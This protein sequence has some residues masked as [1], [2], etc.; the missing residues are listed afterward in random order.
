VTAVWR[1]PISGKVRVQAA[2][3]DADAN[4][5]NGIDWALRHR[6]RTVA[7][8]H[9]ENAGNIEVPAHEIEVQAGD[10]VRL[11]IGP[12][13]EYS[14]DS[15]KVEFVIATG[16]QQWR[17]SE[18]FVQ[19][20]QLMSF[21]KTGFILAAGDAEKLGSENTALIEER[22]QLR[23]TL[24]ELPQCQGLQDGGI[25]LTAYEGFHDAKI[26][27]RGS[28]DRQGELVPRRFPVLLA[29]NQQA[30]IQKGS[31]RLELARWVASA[32]HPLTA[33][34]M[35]N[36]L[37]QHHF[38]EGI[39]RT[40]NNY[41]KLGTPPTHPELLDW[42]ALKFIE[43]GWSIKAMHRLM[44]LTQ[45]YQRA[46]DDAAPKTDAQNL[47][48]GRQNR[49]RLSAEEL[50][51]ALLAATGT[52]DATQG[53]LS[54]TNINSLRRTLYVTTIR[55]DRSSYQMLFDGADPNTIVEKRNDSIVAPQALWL[56]NHPF[57]LDRAKALSA[58]A[59]SKAGTD[60]TQ[61]IAWLY[62]CL[63]N[64]A[65]LPQE[66]ALLQQAL[67]AAPDRALA[68]EQVCHALLCSNEFAYVD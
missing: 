62:D 22:Q 46:A 18:S 51:D 42:L 58:R 53:G 27:I 29:G 52:L 48:F 16:A 47:W 43:N 2:L 3:S 45:T 28:Y 38:G 34:V 30:R 21:D 26:H 60:V 9:M 7:S 66:N 19:Q 17:L 55:S 59:Q 50:R 8:G 10:L 25:A 24:T 61:R 14:C 63:F 32:E 31:G 1:A 41:G 36:R 37:W 56:I 40:P 54:I 6:E 33:R 11:V 64:R 49:R 5:G 4:C 35:V 68:W 13:G 39:V 44:M 65:P 67:S 15:T 23:Q 57:A 20:P 12:R